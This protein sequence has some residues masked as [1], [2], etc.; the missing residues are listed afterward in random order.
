MHSQSSCRKFPNSRR[1]LGSFNVK[2]T[3]VRETICSNAATN[4]LILARV[5]DFVRKV[6]G[7]YVPFAENGHTFQVSLSICPRIYLHLTIGRQTRAGTHVCPQTDTLCCKN[8][9]YL[10]R[11]L[12]IQPRIYVSART[13]C[14]QFGRTQLLSAHICKYNVTRLSFASIYGT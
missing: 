12:Y 14:A 6:Y 11:T 1:L 4:S 3:E 10:P 2:R 8:H 9:S 5:R 7:K 13:L